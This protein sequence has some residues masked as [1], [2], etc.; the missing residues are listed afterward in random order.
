RRCERAEDEVERPEASV[1][2]EAFGTRAGASDLLHG[3]PGV[4][5]A[6]ERTDA[7]LERVDQR[8]VAALEP[9]HHL[10][11]GAVAGLGHALRARPDVRGGKVV[12]AAVQLGGRAGR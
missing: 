3:G 2:D 6:A 1:D 11:A 7:G 10:G 8:L 12:V 5:L 9:A 4:E